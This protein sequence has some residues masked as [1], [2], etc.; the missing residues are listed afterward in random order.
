[1]IRSAV[2]RLLRATAASLLIVLPLGSAQALEAFDGRVQAHGFFES[3]LRVISDDF[4]GDFDL[5]QW[6]QVLN[7]ELEIDVVEDGWGYIDL[8]QA[9]VRIEARYDCVYS[10][11]CGMMKG[12]DAYGDRAKNL[13]KRVAS[14]KE[15][16]YSGAIFL[17]R[18]DRR[19][20]E[21]VDTDGDGIADTTRQR[22]E[23]TRNGDRIVD[24]RKPIPL[25]DVPG[26]SG[27]G[28]QTGADGYTGT[29]PFGI[30][31]LND[32]QINP[33]PE[34]GFRA[35]RFEDETNFRP[36]EAS[37]PNGG[38]GEPGGDWALR[39]D[40]PFPTVF[41]RFEE[42]RFAHRGLRGGSAGGMPV[43]VMGPW[44][45]KNFIFANAMFADQANPF[46]ATVTTQ[47]LLDNA[48]N[49]SLYSNTIYCPDYRSGLI[50]D[51]DPTTFYENALRQN[52]EGLGGE[53]KDKS[54]TNFI[55]G[56]EAT[57]SS[58]NIVFGGTPPGPEDLGPQNV[59]VQAVGTSTSPNRRG[60]AKP[61]RPVPIVDAGRYGD[62]DSIARGVYY[63]S[64]PLRQALDAGKFDTL[65]FNI[66]ETSRAWNHGASQDE[67]ELKEAYLDI[68]TWDSRLWLRLGKQNI[69]WGK[70]ELFRTTDQFNPVDL[71]LVTL[72]NLEETRI[73]LWSARAVLSLYEIG[74]F[75]DVRL[76]F[77][78]NIDDFQ[79]NDFGACGEPFTPNP[80][81]DATFGTFAHGIFG[82]GLA[83]ADAPPAPWED[84]SKI[85]FGARVEWRWDRFSFAIADFYGYEDLPFV[86]RISTYSR[87]VDPLTGRMRAMGFD[88]IDDRCRYQPLGARQKAPAPGAGNVDD[89]LFDEAC[90]QTGPTR[91]DN[92][93][94][95][96]PL[97][98]YLASTDLLARDPLTG[99]ILIE[100]FTDHPGN[101]A[102][103]TDSDGQTF[104][105]NNSLDASPINQQFFAAIC[106]GT[107]G[108]SALDPAACAGTIFGSQQALPIQ[109]SLFRTS[110]VI[111]NFL[112]GSYF[113]ETKD[114][115]PDQRAPFGFGV[116][117]IAS[118]KDDLNN[119][120]LVIDKMV[121][122]LN[123][124]P[125]DAEFGGSGKWGEWLGPRVV[126]NV[127]F[128]RDPISYVAPITPGATGNGGCVDNSLF[129]Q[130]NSPG[131]PRGLLPGFKLPVFTDNFPIPCHSSGGSVDNLGQYL[132]PEQQALL[133]CGPF[134]GT[135][136]GDSGIDLLNAE[137][138]VLF[139]SFP[140][141]DGS[142][143]AACVNFTGGNPDA[144][145][146]HKWTTNN[147]KFD[148]TIIGT[149]L[150]ADGQ[151]R[152][153]PGTMFF[154]GGPVGKVVID[155]RT[156]EQVVLPGARK[157]FAFDDAGD[158]VENPDYDPLV[159]GCVGDST[160]P[161]YDPAG[162]HQ[163]PLPAECARSGSPLI[164][165][166]NL[167]HPLAGSGGSEQYFA[168]EMAALS[169]NFL[170][171]LTVNDGLFDEKNPFALCA[172]DGDTG[173]C[174]FDENGAPLPTCS[175]ATPQHCGTVR[176]L[177]GL[178]GLTRN[179]MRAGGDGTFGR[180]TF[181]WQSGGEAVL[182]FARRNMLGFS[183]DF[184]EDFTKANFALEATWIG[185]VPRASA[186][187]FS[188]VEDASDYN[189]TLSIDRPT[190]VNFLNANRTFFFNT[191]WF[192]RYRDFEHSSGRWDLLGTF[193]ILAGYFQDRLLPSVTFVYDIRSNTGAV[194]P[195]VQYRYT[196]AFSIAVGMQFF[197]G[198]PD[199]GPISVNGLGPVGNQQG[200][201]AYQQ[202]SD[203]GVSIVRH[204]DNFFIRLRYSF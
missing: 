153:Q 203:V 115:P 66:D 138:S 173:N 159:D 81:C 16:T 137:A 60:T 151:D 144:T 130:A 36:G 201:Y 133:G 105:L 102:D 75:D 134:F 193:T 129:D 76:E 149:P 161:L 148:G 147:F 42:F 135:N 186:E 57:A 183:G 127:F 25:Q 43:A 54:Y 190:F 73:A 63:P 44:L 26:F 94:D 30:E 58:R 113:A 17:D 177:L 38:T 141:F 189:I 83:G 185:A 71:A 70:T 29:P 2:S 176:G 91:R 80:V 192:F 143:A 107:I 31:G 165:L 99:Q 142:G 152:Q 50:R 125:G 172:E 179:T 178:A 95:Q 47:L 195:Q 109:A 97:N 87:N 37:V 188:G 124:D 32:L 28:D 12:A 155:R 27:L 51:D 181:I 118:V 11:G 52:L 156:G 62:G 15:S 104:G 85:E 111:G 53:F 48:Y 100:E 187:T 108:V 65:P 10:R 136:C 145:L 93:F 59:L 168:S 119:A 96:I 21:F 72:G 200:K 126:N 14:G 55:R 19:V 1:M 120:P 191:Q 45:P 139:Q 3:Q 116:A 33:V 82:V 114:L 89:I 170:V 49:G 6:Y 61:M 167:I 88:S 34:K 84:A 39:F 199:L 69:V 103:A 146:P 112:T 79:S 8:L 196:E 18:I 13:P 175:F 23:T 123:N 198:R 121:M 22:V 9:Y 24:N 67:G 5:A 40:D 106:A 163:L 7:V 64:R 160:H 68:E 164:P 86:D 4:S 90:L 20:N 204:V 101:Y 202:A 122:K 98:T 194:L 78:A 77:A 182:G 117:A 157:P 110:Q 180:R 166:H 140:G 197:A 41:A 46:D 92:A 154:R 132:T 128:P 74:P 150:S 169:W 184:A 158:V 56:A 171:L 35:W 162:D 174:A 131:S